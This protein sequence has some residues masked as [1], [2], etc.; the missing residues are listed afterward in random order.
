MKWRWALLWLSAMGVALLLVFTF[1]R[2]ERIREHQY[3]RHPAPADNTWRINLTAAVNL[4]RFWYQEGFFKS[5]MIPRFYPSSAENPF[6]GPYYLSYPPLF[7]LAPLG[8]AYVTGK[9]PDLL[10]LTRIS[11][12]SQFLMA[13]FAAA[14]VFFSAQATGTNH[15]AA[16]WL[17]GISGSL[18]LFI[19]A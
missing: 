9:P 2:A 19:P 4:T 14:F 16:L 11:V 8:L 12:A 10:S 7:I 1:L 13:V 17:G 18:A 6:A 3:G 15:P 5:G